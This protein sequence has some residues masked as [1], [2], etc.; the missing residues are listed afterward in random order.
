M[1]TK[2]NA[3]EPGTARAAFVTDDLIALLQPG[4]NISL[5][6]L[7]RVLA[8]A[9]RPESIYTYMR[10][11]KARELLTAIG[12]RRLALRHDAFDA[13]P[14]STAAEHLRALLMHHGMLPQRG[15]EPLARFERWLSQKLDALPDDST[16]TVIERFAAWHHLNRIRKRAADPA[17]NLET[18]IHAAKQEITEAANLLIWLADTHGADAASLT[19]AHIDDYLA[20]GPSTRKHIRNYARWLNHDRSGPTRRLDAPHRA[21]KSV[22]MLT[23]TQRITLVRNCLEWERVGI[24]LRV[25]GLILLLWAQPLNKIVMLRH[26]HLQRGPTGMTITLG[27]QPAAVPEAIAELFW[28]HAQ[29]PSNQRTANISTDWLFPGTRAGAHLSAATLSTRLKVLG[30][31]AQRARNAT[32]RDLV[33]DVDARSLINLLGYSSAVITK[34]AAQTGTGMSD[35]V[36]LK[37]WRGQHPPNG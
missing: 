19:Q 37:R 36:D 4:D 18:V 26:E 17:V 32:L 5:H 27:T 14:R 8:D 25:A 30:I 23:E 31:D 29:H 21:A 34:H 24:S 13:L 9:E 12:E 6:R 7:V 10:G 33:H 16:R 1:A 22:P 28:H 35:Y 20:D 15:P 3:F 2:P 11:A